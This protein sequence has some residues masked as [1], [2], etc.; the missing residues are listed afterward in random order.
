MTNKLFYLSGLIIGCCATLSGAPLPTS[1]M[2]SPLEMR[3]RGYIQAYEPYTTFEWVL[4]ERGDVAEL[5]EWTSQEIPKPDL[6]K[7]LPSLSI[8]AL[9][10]NKRAVVTSGGKKT[11]RARTPEEIQAQLALEAAQ[12]QAE[13]SPERLQLEEEYVQLVLALES[14]QVTTNE[15]PAGSGE[16]GKGLIEGGERVVRKAPD[17]SVLAVARGLEDLVKSDPATAVVMAVKLLA[18]DRRLTALSPN[19]EVDI[20]WPKDAAVEEPIVDPV[21]ETPTK[22]IH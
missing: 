13:K 22:E 5:T 1:P 10:Y 17:R 14:T 16:S 3:V 21:V 2:G 4:D 12:K 7:D 8:L 20:V 6:D 11:W 15:V 19:W 18:L 9:D